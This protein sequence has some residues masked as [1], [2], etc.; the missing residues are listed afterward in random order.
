[1]SFRLSDNF[2]ILTSLL[3]KRLCGFTK[4]DPSFEKFLETLERHHP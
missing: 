2:Y 3:T 1:M 4:A